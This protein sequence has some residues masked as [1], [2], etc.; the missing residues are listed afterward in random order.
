MLRRHQFLLLCTLFAEASCS[1][2]PSGVPSSYDNEEIGGALQTIDEELADG[3]F[4][5]ALARSRIAGET[6]GLS[7]EERQAIQMRLER[8]ALA[9]IEELQQDDGDAESLED[10]FEL[11]LPRQLSVSAGM[12]AAEIHFADGERMDSFRMIRRVDLKYPQHQE[13]TKAGAL[14]FEIGQ[15]FEQ[16][17]GTY[18]LFF[19]YRD[20]APEVFEYLVLNHPSEPRCDEAYW[21][22]AKMYEEDERWDLAIE[23][24]EDLLLWYPASVHVPFSRARIPHLRLA[25]LRSPEYDRTE[26]MLALDE[27]EGWL[28]DFPA[29][30]ETEPELTDSVERDRLDAMQRLADN[31]MTVSR[32]YYTVDNGTGAN[33]HAQRAVEEAVAGGSSAQVEEAQAWLQ[34]V[35]DVY[36][37]DVYSEE[38]P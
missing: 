27:L 18:F 28:I 16:D 8:A 2:L 30:A 38:T 26:M 14:L 6:R 3:R 25:S 22:L 32:F 10:I 17:D 12:R 21:L 7:P 34:K 1:S 15:S 20:N 37:R 23:R 33:Y 35:Q 13:R 5:H 36:P 31:D 11:E 19:D 24:H 29:L 9:R 4:R